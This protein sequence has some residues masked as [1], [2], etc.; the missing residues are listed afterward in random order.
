[1]ISMREAYEKIG[2]NY[3]DACAR[4]MGG[5]MLARFAL[6]FLDDESMDKLEAA[7][8]AGDAEG[9]FMAAHTLKR[10]SQ[11]LGFDNLYEPAVVVTEALRGADAVDGARVRP[12]GLHGRSEPLIQQDGTVPSDDGDGQNLIRVATVRMKTGSLGVKANAVHIY[13]LIPC[14]R[15]PSYNGL[16]CVPA[17]P[18]A[19]PFLNKS[20]AVPVE[21]IEHITEIDALLPI[22]L[23]ET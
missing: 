15:R 14:N 11:N 17:V 13:H 20:L 19:R 2:A 9:A 12:F 8:A 7:M 23:P 21:E 18:A 6:K 4:L 22:W 1:M 16:P 10:V 5:E 3:D